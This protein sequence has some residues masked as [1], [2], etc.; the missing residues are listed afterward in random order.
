MTSLC[1]A[2]LAGK[3]YLAMAMAVSALQKKKFAHHFTRRR[4]KPAEI[5]FPR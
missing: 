3:T 1:T 2:L 5:A 4:W